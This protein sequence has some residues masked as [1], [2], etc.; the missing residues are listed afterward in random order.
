MHGDARDFHGL[1][2]RGPKELIEDG[3]NG[4]L[5]PVQNEEALYEAME[6]MTDSAYA[7]KL[8]DKAYLIREQLTSQEVFESWYAYLF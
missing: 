1:P 5:I 4:L 6:K 7:E 3:I 8:A 2:F